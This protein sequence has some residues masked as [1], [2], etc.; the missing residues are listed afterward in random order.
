MP[1]IIKIKDTKLA[2]QKQ[3]YTTKIS[4]NT[5]KIEKGFSVADI[6]ANFN[7]SILDAEL[8]LQAELSSEASI[9]LSE[10]TAILNYAVD[11]SG[12]VDD[13][14]ATV[15]TQL[16]VIVTDVGALGE[17]LDNIEVEIGPAI[18]VRLSNISRV[19]AGYYSYAVDVNNPNYGD[20]KD[21]N[22]ETW[23]FLGNNL[24]PNNDGWVR[25]NDTN[26][27]I[28]NQVRGWVAT[29]ASLVVNPTTGL[30]TGWQYGDG[31][32][33]DSYFKI[34]ADHIELAG[35]TT[36]SNF[37]YKDMSNVTTIDGGKISTNTLDASAIKTNTLTGNMLYGGVIY[38][39]G[40]NDTTYTMKIDLTNG[41]IH[42][43]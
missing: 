39:L 7:N 4:I 27:G 36:F 28:A 25:Y 30:V 41:E 1:F 12:R 24:G 15:N 37:A 19:Y 26:M 2:I 6:I 22:G 40:G 14:I 42:I 43:K 16:N 11:L 32:G 18:D 29:A 13:N 38:N 5:L 8:R 3:Q 20:L 17:R 31:S 10:D 33:F 9:R 23:Q 35:T 34:S 21:Y